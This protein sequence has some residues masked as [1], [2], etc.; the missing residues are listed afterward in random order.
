MSE[1]QVKSGAQEADFL[2]DISPAEKKGDVSGH[3]ER[4]KCPAC[5]KVFSVEVVVI[6]GWKEKES[7]DC[8]HCGEKEAYSDMCFSLKAHI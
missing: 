6:L 5:N 8:P 7:V 3:T 4:V 1:Q 2:R